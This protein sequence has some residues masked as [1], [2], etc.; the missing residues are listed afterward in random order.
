MKTFLAVQLGL[1]PLVVFWTA[2]GFGHAAAGATAGALLAAVA[3]VWFAR[4]RRDPLFAWISLATLAAIAAALLLDWPPVAGQAVAW[5]QLGLGA[6]AA[7]SVLLGRPW[8]ASFSARE[9]SGVERD[10]LFLRINAFISALWA[11]VFLYLALARFAAFPPAATWLPP[12]MAVAASMLL[13]RAWVRASLARR[14]TQAEGYRWPAPDFSTRRADADVVVVGAGIGGLTAAALLA[15]AGLQVVVAEQHVVAG[16]FCHNWL[17]KGRDGEARPVFRFDAG[18]HDVSGWWPGAPVHGL[19]SRLGLAERLT[20]AR[21]DHR[22]VSEGRV[23]DVPRDWDAYVETLAARFPADAQGIR[24]AM[25]DIR[26][27]HAGMYSQAPRRSGVPGAPRTVEGMLAFARE[28]PLV[29]RWMQRPFMELLASHIAD[30]VARMAIAGLAGYVTDDAARASVGQI[31]PLQGYYLHGGYYPLGGSGRLADALVAVIESHGGEVRLKTAVAAVRIEGGRAAGVR[32][33]RGGE[34]GA[35]AVIVNADLLGATRGL[36]DAS[37]WP[38]EFKR[39]LA[40]LEPACSAFAVH[41][42]VR[43]DFPGVPPI[44]HVE[45]AAGSAGLVIPSQVDPDAAP[46]GYSSVEI[47]RLLPQ[48]QARDWFARPEAH[49]DEALRASADYLQRKQA[50]GDELIR[51]AETALPGLAG[52]IVCRSDASPLTFRRYDWTADG[53]IYGCTGAPAPI[54]VRSPIPGLAFAGAATHGAGIE[55]VMISGA[56][57]AEALRPG[58]LDS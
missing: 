10:P 9:W 13:P 26:V 14:I 12:A 5:S 40:G 46:P 37:L 31:V 29:V 6:G 4:Q 47:L 34:I 39:T 45:G 44:V 16:G 18:V 20:W 50:L 38:D 25:A 32:L 43:G 35:A 24:R 27:I 58:L 19:L 54:G 36:I 23:F 49:D 51:V 15:Q 8:T 57:A 48:A 22:Y 56:L 21:L 55:A 53:A 2:A 28:H 7:A 42:G 41:L 1:L 17:R 3:V 30:P 11:V 52:R 33:A